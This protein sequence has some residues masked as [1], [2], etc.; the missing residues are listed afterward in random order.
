MHCTVLQLASNC[1]NGVRDPLFEMCDE[2][3]LG[4]QRCESLGFTSGELACYADCTLDTSKCND[5]NP[6]G[7]SDAGAEI[8]S[9]EEGDC[10]CGVVGKKGNLSLWVRIWLMMLW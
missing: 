9:P 3:D 2:D 6:D 10:G 8:D 5:T 7:T 1:G 4:N